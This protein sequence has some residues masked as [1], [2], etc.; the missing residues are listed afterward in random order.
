MMRHYKPFST[1]GTGTFPGHRFYFTPDK[2]P[3]TKL[4]TFVIQD[5]P[6][7]LYVYDPY[8][9]KDDPKQTE[10]NLKKHLSKSERKQ[11]DKWTRTQGT[12]PS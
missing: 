4:I 11:Y 8:L 5:Y 1:G 3:S 10:Q 7:N 9:V 2:D 12:C 6:Q